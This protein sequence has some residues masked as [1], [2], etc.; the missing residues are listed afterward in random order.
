MIGD[1]YWYDGG[2]QVDANGYEAIMMPFP[3]AILGLGDA[4][5]TKKKRRLWMATDGT[6]VQYRRVQQPADGGAWQGGG[7]QTPPIGRTTRETIFLVGKGAEFYSR[8]HR[9]VDLLR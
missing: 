1:Q 3:P 7:W 2:I 6:C 5:L 8:V 4:V 9:T